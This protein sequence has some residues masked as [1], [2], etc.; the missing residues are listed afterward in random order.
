MK[1]VFSLANEQLAK[2]LP[3]MKVEVTVGVEPAP[4][5]QGDLEHP[6]MLMDKALYTEPV[7]KP[8]Q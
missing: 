4:M 1:E 5:L 6:V 3:A 7:T 8:W 2:L